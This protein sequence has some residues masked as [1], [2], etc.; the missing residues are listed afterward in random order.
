MGGQRGDPALDHMVTYYSRSA[1]VLLCS[2]NL[3]FICRDCLVKTIH[4]AD[5]SVDGFHRSFLKPLELFRYGKSPVCLNVERF[6][7]DAYSK[8]I[9]Q[10]TLMLKKR[11]W[12]DPTVMQLSLFCSHMS[13][14]WLSAGCDHVVNS[15]SGTISS[16]N[17]PDRYPSKKACT[18]SLSTTP[19]HRI[20]IVC[21]WR[22]SP[23]NIMSWPKWKTWKAVSNLSGSFIVTF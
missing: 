16:P 21:Q 8:R 14:C 23:L 9:P 13:F 15:V 4:T 2:T 22:F 5:L 10:R 12:C 1:I 11:N 20:K 18:W 17:W 6:S 3:I 19:G 7:L